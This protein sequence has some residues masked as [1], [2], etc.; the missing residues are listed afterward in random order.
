MTRNNAVELARVTDPVLAGLG[1]LPRLQ[2]LTY[3]LT[4]L[5]ARIPMFLFEHAGVTNAMLPEG[6]EEPELRGVSL[7]RMPGIGG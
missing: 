7:S 4:S 5:A 6:R 1:S 3:Y 2:L